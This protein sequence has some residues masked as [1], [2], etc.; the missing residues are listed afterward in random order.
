MMMLSARSFAVADYQMSAFLMAVFMKGMNEQETAD[1]TLSM[2]QSGVVADL[3]SC[4]GPLVDKHSTGGVGDKVGVSCCWCCDYC[5]CNF[6][7]RYF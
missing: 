3:S 1:L 4:G 7:T 6:L 5:V 2:V